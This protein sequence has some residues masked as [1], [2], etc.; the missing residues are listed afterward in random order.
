MINKC[1]SFLMVCVL[2]CPMNQSNAQE[3]HATVT[4]SSIDFSERSSNPIPSDYLNPDKCAKFKKMKKAGIVLLI[5]G[6]SLFVAGT[7]AIVVGAARYYDND[8]NDPFETNDGTGLLIGGSLGMVFG[9]AGV[10]AGIPLM[11]I[12]GKKSKQ[13]CHSSSSSLYL[14]PG[15]KGIGLQYRF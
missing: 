11:I 1:L 9:L 6:G 10:G 5:V 15:K 13:Y 12:G 7:A 14:A 4:L 2:V 8:L 3:S